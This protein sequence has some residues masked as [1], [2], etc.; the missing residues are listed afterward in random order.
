[1]ENAGIAVT[2]ER[3]VP[4]AREPPHI[5]VVDDDDEMRDML[6]TM[7]RHAGYAVLE[8]HDGRQLME[9]VPRLVASSTVHPPLDLII[10]DVRMPGCSALDVLREMRRVGASVPVMLITGFGDL[11]LHAEA[12]RLGAEAVYDKPFDP[13]ELR[14]AVLSRLPPKAGRRP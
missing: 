14:D 1:M 3:A 10:S 5:L 7:L 6:V 12:L 4:A 13:E 9:W 2:V 8:G 11:E